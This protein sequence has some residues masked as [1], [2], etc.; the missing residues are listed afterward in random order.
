MTVS[1]ASE[2]ELTPQVI[3]I[4]GATGAIGG[5]LARRYAK[6]GV[7]LHL[8][9]RN[10]A[11]LNGI[12][13][14]CRGLGAKVNTHSIS[15]LDSMALRR[16]LDELDTNSPLDIFIACAGVNINIGTDMSGE[17]LDDMI[18]LLDLNVKATLL[19]SGQIAGFMR[20]RQSGKIGLLSSLA[21]YYGLPLTPSYSASKAAVKAYGE[22]LGGWLAPYNVHVTVIMPGYVDSVMCSE[23]PGP[24]PFLWQPEKAAAV[25]CR[26]IAA[27]R[28]R[29]TFP[30][31]LNLGCWFLS[32][33]PSG[34]SAR[35][36]K[37]LNYTGQ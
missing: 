12:A 1:Y 10:Q 17:K 3:L 31:P 28:A 13:E 6:N 19:M 36:L 5:A 25:I 11:L 33:L 37:L 18:G 34:I 30:F 8:H 26:A 7:L 27:Q 14:E 9:G 21:G 23:M 4:T 32:V 2:T 22:A 15:L 24:K 29:V 35:I 20:Q 16:W